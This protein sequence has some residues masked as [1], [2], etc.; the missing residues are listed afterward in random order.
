VDNWP[1]GRE[2]IKVPTVI[3][4]ATSG[5]IEWGYAISP[6]AERLSW[7]KLLLAEEILPSNV[8]D[9]I[10]LRATKKILY[11]L[12][13]SAE[14]VIADYLRRLWDYTLID[15]RR[16]N[17]KSIYGLPFRI[18]VGVPV[19][20]PPD[21]QKK[22][23]DAARQAGLLDQR[24]GG[25]ATTLEFVAEPEAAALAAFHEGNIQHNIQVGF[26]CPLLLLV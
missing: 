2:H 14:E 25:L 19:N 13:K 11:R 21:A 9:S 6:D 4:Y 16:Q 15:I 5:S 22:M 26:S 23:R 12:K 18:V 7:F 1:S 24:A 20:W 3:S 8:R 17:P 10:Q